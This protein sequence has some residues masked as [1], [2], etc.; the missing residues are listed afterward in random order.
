[1][2]MSMLHSCCMLTRNFNTKLVDY[3]TASTCEP[4]EYKCTDGK[5][6]DKSKVCDGNPNDCSGNNDEAHCSTTCQN[7]RKYTSRYIFYR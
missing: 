1:M 3:H 2:F 6:I 4:G 7:C 5:C